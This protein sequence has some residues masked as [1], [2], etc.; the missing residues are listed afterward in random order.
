MRDEKGNRVKGGVRVEYRGYR[1]YT[2][3]LLSDAG[4][5]DLELEERV[6]E[7]KRVERNIM[8][9]ELFFSRGA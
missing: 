5:I 2:R 7:A 9:L 6:E 4:L 1:Q 3:S 8:K